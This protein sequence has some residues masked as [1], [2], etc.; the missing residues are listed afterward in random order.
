MQL[1]LMTEKVFEFKMLFEVFH[2]IND[3][4]ILCFFVPLQVYQ[5]WKSLNNLS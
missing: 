5:Q 2:T 1:I 3:S 4:E